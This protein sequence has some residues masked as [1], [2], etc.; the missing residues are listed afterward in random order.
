MTVKYLLIVRADENGDNHSIIGSSGTTKEKKHSELYQQ[1]TLKHL[2]SVSHQLKSYCGRSTMECDGPDQD[3]NMLIT[4]GMYS[5]LHRGQTKT[6]LSP[7]VVLV[8]FLSKNIPT[9]RCDKMINEVLVGVMEKD[10]D[11][12]ETW[13]L[14]TYLPIPFIIQRT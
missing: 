8:F 1:Y 14:P 13:Y 7:I 3:T 5:H 6:H 4:C 2:R 11:M 9:S 10:R 12:V